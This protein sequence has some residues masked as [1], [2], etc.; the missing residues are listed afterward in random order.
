M[1][2][3]RSSTDDRCEFITSLWA[4][5][6]VYN[7]MFVT[8]LLRRVLL[9]C[10]Y[11]DGDGCD[12]VQLLQDPVLAGEVHVAAAAQVALLRDQPGAA[13]LHLL[14]A[15]CPHVPAAAPVYRTRRRWFVFIL[16]L[17]RVDLFLCP[18]KGAKYCDE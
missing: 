18:G 5:T 12:P 16:K 7:T 14:R 8:R 1:R 4:S 6:F 3:R 13:L 15:V 11:V 9:Q 2:C 10:R 17:Y